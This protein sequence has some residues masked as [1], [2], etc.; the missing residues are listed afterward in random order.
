M[1]KTVRLRAEYEGVSKGLKYLKHKV[2]KEGAEV[3][4]Y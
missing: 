3:T 2:H 4:M 1:V